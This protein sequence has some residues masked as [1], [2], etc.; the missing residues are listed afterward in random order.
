PRFFNEFAIRLPKPAAEVV[1]QLANH[2]ILAGVPYSRLAP[3]AGMDDVLL[4]AATETTT[5]AD[6]KILATALA[7]VLAN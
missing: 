4:V 1:E 5:D 2:H 3:D 7:K 6:I